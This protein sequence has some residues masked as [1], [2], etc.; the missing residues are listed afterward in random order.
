VSAEDRRSILETGRLQLRRL[1]LH[2]APFI[3]ALLN[4]PDFIRFIGD[5]GVRSEVDARAYLQSGPLA[6]YAQF[7][8]G[9]FRV[10]LRSDDTPI[11]L[12]GMLKRDGLDDADIGFAFLPQHI[13]RG[14][15]YEIASAL[16]AKVG[17]LFGLQRV[18]AIT[19]LENERSIRLLMKLGFEFEK[20]IT[21]PSISHELRLFG[22]RV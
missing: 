9:L 4:D 7:G 12:C 8:F 22:R 2:D 10:G 19:N 15:A 16:L 3:V 14:Y 21:L 5:R 18:V 1:E 20:L 11:G 6:S 17:A 13:S